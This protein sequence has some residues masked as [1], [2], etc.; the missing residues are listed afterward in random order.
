METKPCLPLHRVQ[1]G[2]GQYNT[3][4]GNY[5]DLECVRFVCVCRAEMAVGDQLL[6][7]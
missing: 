7:Q 3:A 2:S 4:A 1:P 6:L 5:F